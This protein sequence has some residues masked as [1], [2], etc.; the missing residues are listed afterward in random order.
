ML[1]EFAGELQADAPA[2]AT[3]ARGPG[4]LRARARRVRGRLGRAARRPARRLRVGLEPDDEGAGA[5]APRRLPG[6]VHAL[7]RLRSADARAGLPL[8]PRSGAGA[9]LRTRHGRAVRA[10]RRGARRRCA[11]GS[12]SASRAS[13]ARSERAHERAVRAKAL[14]L[15]RGLLPAA[16]LSHVG[17]F[18]SGQTFERL[19]MH[20]RAEALP[21]ARR[22]GGGDARRRCARSPPRFMT[23]V[24]RPERGGAWT[25]FLRRRAAAETLAAG[26]TRRPSPFRRG[27]RGRPAARR[28][29]R[30]AQAAERA[31][32]RAGRRQREAGRGGGRGARLRGARGAARANCSAG[33]RTAATCPGAV[34]RRCATASRSSRTTARSATCSATACSR[35]NGSRSART[36][37]PALPEQARQAG[38]GELFER[39]FERSAS[40]WQRLADAGLHA[41][42]PYAL[43][44]A[45]RIRYVLDMNARE[46]MHLIELRSGREGH[47]SYRAIA[48]ADARADRRGAPRRRGRDEPPRHERRTAPGA[49]RGG[50]SGRGPPRPARSAGRPRLSPDGA[51]ADLL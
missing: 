39:A 42:A 8:P 25:E 49:D 14:D 1:D 43:C 7:H 22:C 38:L 12:P 36:S 41:Q 47:E 45:F 5:P 17:I 11:R 10:L 24:D 50:A 2:R 29:G 40:A 23:R 15:A 37:A 4:A 26:R 35:R 32:V 6:A 34:W 51:P 9:G 3:E 21:E 18:A 13:P 30:R 19:V 27:R 46:A 20:L 28:R 33:A 48:H 44:L 16:T 31:R